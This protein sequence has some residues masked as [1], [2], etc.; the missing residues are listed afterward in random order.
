MILRFL[1]YSHAPNPANGYILGLCK[2]KIIIT[3]ATW[4]K[5]FKTI[6]LYTH[7]FRTTTG[8]LQ[9]KH[10]LNQI[11]WSHL[12][13]NKYFQNPNSRSRVITKAVDTSA[14]YQLLLSRTITQPRSARGTV[15]AKESQPRAVW[16]SFWYAPSATRSKTHQVGG[17]NLLLFSGLWILSQRESDFHHRNMPAT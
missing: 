12:A 6:L 15:R 1:E 2:L 17:K 5:Y 3:I 7:Y 10:F 11:Y 8:D 9:G 14:S 4:E 13:L 16:Q